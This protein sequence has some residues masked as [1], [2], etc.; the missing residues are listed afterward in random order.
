MSDHHAGPWRIMD[1]EELT[2]P[3]LVDVDGAALYYLESVEANAADEALLASAPTLALEVQALRLA[4]EGAA[5]Y[6]A[7]TCGTDAAP[8]LEK[9]RAI[10]AD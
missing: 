6:I 7:D 9:I 10:L 5:E 2:L 3:V 4:L 1:D 8:V